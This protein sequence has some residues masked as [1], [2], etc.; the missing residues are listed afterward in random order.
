VLELNGSAA[1]ERVQVAV[2]GQAQRVP[3]AQRRLCTQLVF[4]GTQRRSSVIGPV[5]PGASGQAI[6]KEHADDRHHG[7][8]AVG[9]L[10]RQLLGLLLGIRRSQ[11]LEAVVTRGAALVV[12][13]ATAELDKAKVRSDLSPSCHWHLRDCRKPIRDVSELKASRW[14]QESRQF[15]GD[16]W[17][18]ISHGGHHRD[19]SVLQ[20]HGSAALERR[21]ITVRGKSYGVPEADGRLNAQLILEG[22]QVD[23]CW[24]NISESL[25]P[26]RGQC[27]HCRSSNRQG[28]RLTMRCLHS[29][30]VC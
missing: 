13:E 2:G 27:G 3:E 23:P 25:P 28:C 26:T 1:L 21:H 17:S 20:F 15:P 29:D 22:G 24:L 6:L 4:E 12:I 9:Q 7:Q 16:L 8:S 14:R 10:G 19:A 11:H 5:T 30:R 18:D